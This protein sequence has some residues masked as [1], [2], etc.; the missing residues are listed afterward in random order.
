M[1]SSIKFITCDQAGK[2]YINWSQVYSDLNFNEVKRE[3]YV[4]NEKISTSLS[5]LSFYLEEYGDKILSNNDDKVIWDVLC[6]I[7]K[8]CTSIT[9][10]PLVK[11]YMKRTKDQKNPDYII[12]YIGKAMIT[13]G[14]YDDYDKVSER[15]VRRIVEYEIS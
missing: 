12:M 1:S 11:I 4:P 8:A 5:N 2:T 10:T 13:Y 7:S 15:T 14:E 3:Q 9:G 6:I